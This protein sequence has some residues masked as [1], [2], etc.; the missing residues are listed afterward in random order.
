MNPTVTFYIDLRTARITTVQPNMQ[1]R[2]QVDVNIPNGAEFE[3]ALTALQSLAQVM[4]SAKN[5][6]LSVDAVLAVNIGGNR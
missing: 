3:T 1:G 2:V 4:A 5:G 6:Q